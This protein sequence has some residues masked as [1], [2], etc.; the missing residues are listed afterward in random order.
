MNPKASG[1]A[2]RDRTGVE[3]MDHRPEGQEIELT[4]AGNLEHKHSPRDTDSI[5]PPRIRVDSLSGQ[6]RDGHFFGKPIWTTAMK[7]IMIGDEQSQFKRSAR[8]TNR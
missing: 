1:L 7:R 5:V 3:A 6:D 2:E 4:A 8:G